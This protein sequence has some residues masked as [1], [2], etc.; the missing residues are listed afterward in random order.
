MRKIV[1]STNITLDGDTEGME[2]WHFGLWNDEMAKLANDLLFGS[3]TLLMGRKLYEAFQEAWTQQAGADAFAD[4]MNS[5]EKYVISSTLDKADWANTSVIRGENAM[6]EVARLK[7][8]PGKDILMYGFGPVAKALARHGLLD[9][10][11][12][13]VHPAIAGASTLSQDGFTADLRHTGTETF[14]NGVVVLTYAVVKPGE[15][16]D[17]S[18]GQAESESA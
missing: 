12:F 17:G 9:E 11:R 6:D 5:I 18:E 3:D 16:E 4:R 14:G 1:S 10:V 7:E 2:K 8:R 13:W 15:S